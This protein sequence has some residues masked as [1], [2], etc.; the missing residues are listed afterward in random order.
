MVC[1][2]THTHHILRRKLE[3]VFQKR[4]KVTKGPATVTLLLKLSVIQK[5]AGVVISN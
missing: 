5:A 1:M 2:I 4:Q 3:F